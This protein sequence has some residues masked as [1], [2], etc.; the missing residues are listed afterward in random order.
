MLVVSHDCSIS[1][2][3]GVTGG[4]S[5]SKTIVASK[6]VVSGGRATGAGVGVGV[7]STK[8]LDALGMSRATKRCPQILQNLASRTTGEAH[9]GQLLC[10]TSSGRGVMNGGGGSLK[11]A[12]SMS[13]AGCSATGAG[14]GVG[15]TKALD[16]FGSS[17]TAKR[18]P[19]FLQNLA[20]GTTGDAH[21][22]QLLMD[23]SGAR[24]KSARQ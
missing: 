15:S 3:R 21:F 12:R 9:F 14:V 24:R 17:G 10:S 4:G 8:A 7:G 19:Q 5:G 22:G 20:P 11:S 2:G 16:T 18:C 23:A 6:L 13:V 1:F